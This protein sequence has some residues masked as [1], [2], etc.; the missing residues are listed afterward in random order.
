MVERA[1]RTGT[2]KMETLVIDVRD[3]ED[4]VNYHIPG[5]INIPYSNLGCR[6]GNL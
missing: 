3:N 1:A 2:F 4:F 6:E 5:A